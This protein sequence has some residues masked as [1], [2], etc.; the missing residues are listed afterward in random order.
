M[1]KN[2]I[3][4]VVVVRGG[5]DL[6]SGVVFRLHKIGIKTIITELEKPLAVR[7]LVCFSE[8]VYDGEITIENITARCTST[9]KEAISVFTNGEIPVIIDPECS[10]RNSKEFKI[11][12]I[13]DARMTKREPDLGL[14]SAPLMIGLGPGFIAGV[15]CHAVIETNRGHYLGRVIWDGTAEPDT[16]IPGRI[17]NKQQ[18]RVIRAPIDGILIPHHQIGT[19]IKEGEILA[20]V[21]GKTILAPYNGI[22]RGLLRDGSLVFKGMKIGDLDPRDNPD[23][24]SH[25]SE[26]SLAIGGG[27]IE[28]LLTQIEIRDQLWT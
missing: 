20:S 5:G 6:A 12:S 14:D 18:E 16:G 1:N 9:Y 10:I 8:A 25:I 11:V 17:G 26:K 28:A 3:P 7:R 13:I 21:E 23:I 4:T 22:L 27:V 19:R 15:N 24:A 2:K